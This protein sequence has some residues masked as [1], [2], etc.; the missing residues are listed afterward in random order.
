MEKSRLHAGFKT[1]FC[2]LIAI[3]ALIPIEWVFPGFNPLSPAYLGYTAAYFTLQIALF[4]M[5]LRFAKE[6]VPAAVFFLIWSA[7]ILIPSQYKIFV[8]VNYY[9]IIPFLV[10]IFTVPALRPGKEWIR[11]G[12]IDKVTALLLVL[13]V[14]VASAALAVWTYLAKPD[15][16]GF[17]SLI[18]FDSPL[19]VIGIMLAFSV[20]NAIGEEVIFRGIL[21]DGLNRVIE[22]RAAVVVI[23][24]VLFGAWHFNGF[25]GGVSGMVLVWIWGGMLGW[26]RE[27]SDGML[28]PLL[29]HFFADL[30]IFLLIVLTRGRFA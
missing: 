6:F 9:A 25:P 28:A 26:I 17:L 16:T 10:L 8:A 15:M 11:A 21:Q 29:A 18:P 19:Q 27:R 23:Q 30:T 2:V 7:G 12:K 4:I 22:S 3:F 14:A 24:A 13:T 1:S 5:I 20:F